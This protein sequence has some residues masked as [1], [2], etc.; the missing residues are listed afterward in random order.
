VNSGKDLTVVWNEALASTWQ[1]APVWVHGD[2]AI[3]NLLVENG[4]LSAVIDF[5]QL[6]IGDP[7]CDLA[8]AWTLFTGESRDAFCEVLKLDSATWARGRGWTIWKALCWAFPGSNRIDWRVI[9]EVL[10][11]H[12]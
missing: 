8:I 9:N 12:L 5:G 7:A 3:G 2:I 6:C 4:Q 10:A 11:D 1:R